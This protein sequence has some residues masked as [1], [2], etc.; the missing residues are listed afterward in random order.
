MFTNEWD[1][2]FPPDTQAAN[3]LGADLRNFRTDVMERM[4]AISGPE[5]NRP[6]FENGFAGVI[7]FATDTG[8]VFQWSGAAWTDITDQILTGLY[9]PIDSPVFTGE[10]KAPTPPTEAVGKEIPTVEWVLANLGSD[11]IKLDGSSQLGDNGYVKIGSL[12]VQWCKGIS[13]SN[14][15]TVNFP[16]AFP[17]GCYIVF[18]S[19]FIAG[20]A[21]D[22]ATTAFA[23][24]S[25]NNTGVTV[26]PNRMTDTSTGAETPFIL[27]IGH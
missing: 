14:N 3:Q 27:A 9:A 21:G 10:P 23:I 25:Y 1:N 11:K 15:Q 20:F 22:A 26:H 16:L 7:F 2:N 5:A 12:I 8:K 4:A 24:V 19:C 17:T 6:N 13:S 18:A